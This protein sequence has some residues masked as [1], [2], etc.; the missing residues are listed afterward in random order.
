M[1]QQN[2][3][4]SAEGQIAKDPTFEDFVADDVTDSTRELLWRQASQHMEIM[5][6]IAREMW[7]WLRNTPRRLTHRKWRLFPI[8][9]AN[10]LLVGQFHRVLACVRLDIQ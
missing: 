2:L 4:N 6:K 3:T 8:I 7:E 10:R 5:L 9:C 1:S